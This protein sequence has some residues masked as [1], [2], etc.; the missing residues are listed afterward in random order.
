M[1]KQDE[2]LTSSNTEVLKIVIRKIISN[3]GRKMRKIHRCRIISRFDGWTTK[4][5]SSITMARMAEIFRHR[6]H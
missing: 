3:K 6:R 2:M 5:L 1:I 4:H